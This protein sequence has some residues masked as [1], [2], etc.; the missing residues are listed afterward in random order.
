ME[1]RGWLYRKHQC[2]TTAGTH[3]FNPDDPFK[4]LINNF[5]KYPVNL[6]AKQAVAKIYEHPKRIIKSHITHGE[7]LSITE[8]DTKYLTRYKNLHDVNTVN[9]HLAD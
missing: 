3:H 7:M 5:S 6:Y 9:K 4:L 2:L 1:P 8:S